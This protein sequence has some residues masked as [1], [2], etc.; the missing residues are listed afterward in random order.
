MKKYLII[1]FLLF[2]SFALNAHDSL[3]S[4]LLAR[5]SEYLNHYVYQHEI[6]TATRTLIQQARAFDPNT[7]LI[8]VRNFLY[9][10]HNR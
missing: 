4:S 9:Q 1:K 6:N 5:S 3:Q 2:C 10:L 8:Q 7:S